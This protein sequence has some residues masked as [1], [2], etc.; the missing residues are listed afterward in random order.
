MRPIMRLIQE[1]LPLREK[2][3]LGQVHDMVS[4]GITWDDKDPVGA[5]V[6]AILLLLH[7]NVM[8]LDHLGR[9]LTVQLIT[10]ERR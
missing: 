1:R 3:T 5:T 6:N 8:M 2:L 9:E 7:E 4:D 10:R